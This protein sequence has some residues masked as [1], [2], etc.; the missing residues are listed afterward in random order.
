LASVLIQITGLYWQ[1]N[2]GITYRT[3]LGIPSGGPGQKTLAFEPVT[4]K[5]F[6]FAFLSPRPQ[7]GQ[8]MGGILGMFGI[9]AGAAPAGT[10]IAELVLHTGA[11]VNRFEEKA[12][13]SA[14][15]DLAQAFTPAVVTAI[16]GE[17]VIDLTS[18]MDAD[19]RLEWTPP[20]GRWVILRLG[21]TLTGHQNSPASPEA[22]GLEV[23]KLSAEHVRAY[24]TNYL[25][26]YKDA[27]GGLMGE[28]G[29]QFMITDSWEAGTQTW[30]DKMAEE[31]STRRGY[32]MLQWMPVT[33]R[34]LFRKRR[35]NVKFLW[36]LR[37]TI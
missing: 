4:A 7:Q 15:T 1:A 30:T 22:T 19:G 10:Q 33:G 23:D 24:F 5:Y 9:R 3:V 6:R 28:R 11:R 25:D 16:S 26:Q 35:R 34:L 12:A 29:L 31:F 2:D 32:D 13:F 8:D 18:Q 27:T 14:A 17:D 37:K 36:D 20:E 21:Y